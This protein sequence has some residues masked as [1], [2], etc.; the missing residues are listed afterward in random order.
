MERHGLS[1]GTPVTVKRFRNGLSRLVAGML[2]VVILCACV[3]PAPAVRV[4]PEQ[5]REMLREMRRPPHEYVLEMDRR[6]K[7]WHRVLAINDQRIAELTRRIGDR[8][9]AGRQECRS[10][11]ASLNTQN[12]L[13]K[14]KLDNC[15][16]G[17]RPEWE[18]FRQSFVSDLLRLERSVNE[19]SIYYLQ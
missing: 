2:P 1:P 17:G 16:P 14:K 11:I 13:L 7:D 6:L 9:K 15:Q 5:H 19:F 8:R 10:R 3:R 12:G 4:R 18:V